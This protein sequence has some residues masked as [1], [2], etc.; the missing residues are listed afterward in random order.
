MLN[1]NDTD[2]ILNSIKSFDQP[3]K[4]AEIIERTFNL[5]KT[6]VSLAVTMLD[7]TIIKE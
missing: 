2:A 4:L 7:P 1:D 6:N 3:S 5:N